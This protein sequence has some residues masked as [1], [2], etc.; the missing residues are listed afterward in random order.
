VR[1]VV[2]LAIVVSLA[3]SDTATA[4][5]VEDARVTAET[6]RVYTTAMS[7]YCPGFTLDACPSPQAAVLKDSIRTV[8]KAGASVDEVIASLERQFGDQVRGAPRVTGFGAVA[9]FSPYVLFLLG[10]WF[11][12]R[13]L[14]RSVR[15]ESPAGAPAMAAGLS[16]TGAAPP[17]LLARLEAAVRDDSGDDD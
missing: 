8:I 15:V 14:R 6:R 10:A 2:L 7:P 11:V 3:T 17:E 4:Q 5:V 13:L 9:W 12:T 1:V 16:A